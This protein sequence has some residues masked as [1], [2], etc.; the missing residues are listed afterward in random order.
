MPQESF[1]RNISGAGSEP[2][3]QTFLWSDILRFPV[4]H[5]GPLGSGVDIMKWIVKGFHAGSP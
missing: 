5:V 2:V 4:V 3:K 1:Y